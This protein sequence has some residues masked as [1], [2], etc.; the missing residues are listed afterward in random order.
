MIEL[1]G[2]D[3]FTYRYETWKVNL[4]VDQV[5]HVKEYTGRESNKC[6]SI[7]M[8]ANGQ[9]LYVVERIDAVERKIR[10]YAED[11]QKARFE[12]WFDER[13][14]QRLRELIVAQN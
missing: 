11:A 4:M 9:S 1:T 3:P 12:A 14:E 2:V 7:I 13:L 6:G 5:T 8:L 10:A